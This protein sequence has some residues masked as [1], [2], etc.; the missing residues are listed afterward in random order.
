[1]QYR[2]MV[3]G[4]HDLAICSRVALHTSMC[5]SCATSVGWDVT[6]SSLVHHSDRLVCLSCTTLHHFCLCA[7]ADLLDDRFVRYASLRCVSSVLLRFFEDCPDQI[8]SM[9]V[10][11]QPFAYLLAPACFHH[12]YGTPLGVQRDAVCADL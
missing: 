8:S 3:R 1:M 11:A 5:R 4:A 12:A 10:N 6:Q 2:K 9:Q 7:C